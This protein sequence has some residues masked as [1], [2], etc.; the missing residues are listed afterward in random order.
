MNQEEIQYC[1][2]QLSNCAD[3]PLILL[4]EDGEPCYSSGWAALHTTKALYGEVLERLRSLY[5]QKELPVTLSAAPG[6]LY[7]YLRDQQGHEIVLGPCENKVLSPSERHELRVRFGIEEK[8]FILPTVTADQG[9]SVL[10]LLC[11]MMNGTLAGS[12]MET[13]A[14]KVTGEDRDRTIAEL[15]EYYRTHQEEIQPHLPYA[16]EKKLW[17]AV[18]AGDEEQFAKLGDQ[19]IL[20]NTGAVAEDRSKQAEYLAVSM[21]TLFCRSAIR[22]GVADYVSYALSDDLLRKLEK[23]DSVSTIWK[24]IAET[25]AVYFDAIRRAKRD[26]SKAQDVEKCKAYIA[27]HLH[28]GIRVEEMAEKIGMNRSSLSRKFKEA[29]GIS[30]R[31]YIQREKIRAATNL[32]RYSDAKIAEIADWLQFDSPS[33]FG[34]MFRQATGM[35]PGQYRDGTVAVDGKFV[36][37]REKMQ[38][39]Q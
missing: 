22:A 11:Y 9:M 36:P 13:T 2:L 26:N 7:G 37:R 34:K 18:E 30:I 16:Y 39:K 35:T 3:V 21:I 33:S 17:D 15:E 23:A 4:G 6:I 24:V 8:G 5:A 10:R 27:Q 38:Q 28:T 31:E 20:G 14:T 25:Q 19:V 1:M 32:L 29:E 12:R